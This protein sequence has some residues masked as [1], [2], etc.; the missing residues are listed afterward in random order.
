VKIRPGDLILNDIYG[1]VAA[2]APIVEKVLLAAE[3]CYLAE[4]SM[5]EEIGAGK[6][7]QKVFEK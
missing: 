4:R 5:K 3:E 7:M 6:S 2:P 1:V